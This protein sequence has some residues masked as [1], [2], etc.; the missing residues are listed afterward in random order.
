MGKKKILIMPDFHVG[1]NFPFG[2][3]VSSMKKTGI[4]FDVVKDA[5]FTRVPCPDKVFTEKTGYDFF[6]ME[7]EL[8]KGFRCEWTPADQIATIFRK[9]KGEVIETIELDDTQEF[10]TLIHFL[11]K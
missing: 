11:A 4:P 9:H 8:M 10:L 1:T 5:G 6:Y 2:D 7:K 3:F